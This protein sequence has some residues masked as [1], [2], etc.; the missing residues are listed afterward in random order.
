MTEQ[1]TDFC[2]DDCRDVVVD[3]GVL[4][5]PSGSYEVRHGDGTYALSV[6]LTGGDGGWPCEG[7]VVLPEP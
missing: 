4:D 5:L 6:P 7:D 3:C 2:T 1:K